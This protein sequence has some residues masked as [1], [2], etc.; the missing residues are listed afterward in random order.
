MRCRWLDM[1]ELITMVPS[2]K[3]IIEHAVNS[4]HNFVAG[5]DP[6]LHSG[7]KEFS[8]WTRNESEWLSQNRKSDA[9]H[10]LSQL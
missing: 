7:Y 3:A 4:W 6:Q 5:L 2:K 10:L 8:S 1:D 9:G